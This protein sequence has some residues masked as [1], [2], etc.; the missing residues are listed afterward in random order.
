MMTY[1]VR[2][3]VISEGKNQKIMEVHSVT[4]TMFILFLLSIG[5]DGHWASSPFT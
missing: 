1:L 5:L 2:T 3:K 4:F